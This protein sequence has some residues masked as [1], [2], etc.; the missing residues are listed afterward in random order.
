MLIFDSAWLNSIKLYIGDNYTMYGFVLALFGVGMMMWYY[1][2][3]R[4]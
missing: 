3:K 4:R 1:K 2:E